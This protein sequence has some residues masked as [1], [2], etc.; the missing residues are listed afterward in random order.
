MADTSWKNNNILREERN[1][2]RYTI[3]AKHKNFERARFVGATDDFE[4]AKNTVE[5]QITLQSVKLCYDWFKI[6]DTVTN[7]YIIYEVRP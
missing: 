3:Y 2:D 6:K 5:H 1:M 7:K 4:E